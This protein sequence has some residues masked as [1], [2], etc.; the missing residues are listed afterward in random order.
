M[1][2]GLEGKQQSLELAGVWAYARRRAM[3]ELQL[4]WPGETRL[5]VE[6]GG[7]SVGLWGGVGAGYHG[8]CASRWWDL[9]LSWIV[10]KLRIIEERRRWML[11]RLA[12]ME[13]LRLGR[14]GV[15]HGGWWRRQG[16]GDGD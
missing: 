7:R 5:W 8:G 14:M 15:G 9:R 1:G 6:Q 3:V 11:G 10:M 12:A 13:R 16:V 4:A 2:L